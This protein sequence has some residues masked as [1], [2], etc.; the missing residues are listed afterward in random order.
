MLRR[1]EKVNT[2]TKNIDA[3]KNAL[4][5]PDV[6]EKRIY[7]LLIDM[8]WLIPQTE[9][10]VRRAEQSLA[11]VQ[12]SQLPPEL[13]DPYQFINQLDKPELQ[14]FSD[15]PLT[16]I[17]KASRELGFSD[18][19]LVERTGLSHVL[20]TMFDLRQ[21]KFITTPREVVERIAAA[22]QSSVEQVAEYLQ[23]APRFAADANYKADETAPELDEPQD[24]AEAVLD[25]PTLT[26]ERQQEL[27]ALAAAHSGSKT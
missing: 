10:D 1:K 26:E 23:G 22:I 3:N 16:G 24:F 12:L 20:V 18:E 27:L 19:Q 15:A 21:I 14:H 9:E 6:G 13:A 5:N 7:D 11:R 8:G 17:L 25:D 2:M 4:Q